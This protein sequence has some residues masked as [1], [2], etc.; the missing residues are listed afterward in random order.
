MAYTLA[1]M[2]K[3]VSLELTT[4]YNPLAPYDYYEGTCTAVSGEANKATFSPPLLPGEAEQYV[5]TELA[6]GDDAAVI[7]G[8]DEATGQATITGTFTAG[9]CAL[10]NFNGRG[11]QKSV[12]EEAVKAAWY[13]ARSFCYE[14]G[15]ETLVVGDDETITVTLARVHSIWAEETTN[16]PALKLNPRT[17]RVLP[18]SKIYVRAQYDFYDS[19]RYRFRSTLKGE[20]VV[21]EGYNLLDDDY[22]GDVDAHADY[23]IA[24]AVERL[25]FSRE[26]SVART[27]LYTQRRERASRRARTWPRSNTR[28]TDIGG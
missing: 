13:E 5:G 14:D 2:G 16:R 23:M 1:S 18:E 3:R 4:D 24:H 20:N 22:T 26:E 25:L 11:W 19:Y 12:V 28:R 27:A 21:V 10:R 6:T 15:S 17:W 9:A 7:T 8:W